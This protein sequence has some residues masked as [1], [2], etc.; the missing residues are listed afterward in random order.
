MQMPEARRHFAALIERPQGEFRLAEAALYLAQE[1]YPEMSVRTY[2][3]RIDEMAEAVKAEL[4]LELDPVRI[5]QEI[6]THLFETLG[7][8]GNWEQYY[9]PR[10]SFLNDVIDRGL[11]IPITLSTIYIEVGRLV[12]LP[13]AGVGMPGHF[14]VQYTAQPEPFWIDP[15]ERGTMMTRDACVE[16][17][18]GIYGEQV[19][20]RDEFLMP[21]SD[22]NILHRILNNLKQNYI[23]QHDFHRALG[24][25]ES[26]LLLNP[27]IPT[28]VRDR[29][30]VHSQ[31]GHWQAA[32]YDLQRYLELYE[33][34]PDAAVIS[35]HIATLRQRLES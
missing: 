18:R 2:L 3:D 1:E 24:A 4:G 17:L 8:R 27:E 34:A 29:G 6:N 31:L 14:I 15:F 7:F 9:D 33:E 11:G 21:I 22:H 13:I 10:N 26:I 30:F 19:P 25:I 35:H 5:V 12:G 32:L 28:E 23:R 16:R 20:W